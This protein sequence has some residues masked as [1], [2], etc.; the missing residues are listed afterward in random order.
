MTSLS[1]T[2]D[3]L[4]HPQR[5]SFVSPTEPQKS[6]TNHLGVRSAGGLAWHH[7][8]QTPVSETSVTVPL[9]MLSLIFPSWLTDYLSNSLSIYLELHRASRLH[10]TIALPRNSWWLR[11]ESAQAIIKMGI[12]NSLSSRYDEPRGQRVVYP[13]PFITAENC[14]R[15]QESPALTGVVV[16]WQIITWHLPF[17][18]PK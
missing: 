6:H 13:E 7:C 10:L 17:F 15:S 16:V 2:Q 4:W 18:L 14:E 9:L 1:P 8:Q 3:S 5:T 11:W 12:A